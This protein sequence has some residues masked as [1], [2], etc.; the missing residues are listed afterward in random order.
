M[1]LSNNAQL[2]KLLAKPVFRASEARKLGI[3]PSRLSYYVKINLVERINRGVYRG[4]SSEVNADFQW[5]DLILV[6]KSLPNG[7]VC[8]ISALAVYGLTEEIPRQH[9]IAIP[10]AT[11][12]PKR[13]NTRFIRMRD[14]DTGKSLHQLGNETITIFDKERTVV[15]AFRF[16]SKEIAIKSLKEAA[17]GK[18]GNNFNFKKLQKYAKKFKI[19]LTPYILMVTT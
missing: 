2:E 19:D 5:E 6:S 15:D 12:A 10:H 7:I 1:K 4:T 16:L 18:D 3:H 14:I 17:K 9:W 8:L 11:T 13:E